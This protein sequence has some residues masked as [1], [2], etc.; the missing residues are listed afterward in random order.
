MEEK[1]YHPEPYWSDVAQRILEREDKN[2]IAGDDEPYYRYKR[3][4]FLQML[5]EVDFKG[6]SVMELG[7]GPGGNLINVAKH[8]PKRLVGAD[9][10]NDMIRLAT[11]NTEGRAELVKIDGTKLPFEDDTFD[12][13]FTATVL[14]HNTD[15]AML[16]KIMAELCRVCKGNIYLF[17]R[18]E[19][20]EIK[21]D[22]LCKGRPVSYYESICKESGFELEEVKFI[23]IETSYAVAGVTRNW[24][25]SKSRAEGEPLNKPSLLIQSVLLPVTKVLDNVFTSK[26]NMGRLKFKKK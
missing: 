23:N 26:R 15:D 18:I 21:G 7:S 22:D 25:N 2:V 24:L 4:K 20:N 17:E 8:N 6:K 14:Q 11:K 5:H 9:I 10:S 16:R 13:V 19:K 1:N 12:I 3:E